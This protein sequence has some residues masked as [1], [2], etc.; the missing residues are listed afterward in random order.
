[1][2]VRRNEVVSRRILIAVGE[3]QTNGVGLRENQ[4]KTC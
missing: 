4:K 2:V 1:V 3:D